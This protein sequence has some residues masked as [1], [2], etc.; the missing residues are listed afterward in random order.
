[1]LILVVLFVVRRANDDPWHE[2]GFV[3]AFLLEMVG[4]GERHKGMSN[5]G[6]CPGRSLAAT[7]CSTLPLASGWPTAARLRGFM[8]R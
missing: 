4:L 8:R 7:S 5:T 3:P 2:C 6:L 1:M